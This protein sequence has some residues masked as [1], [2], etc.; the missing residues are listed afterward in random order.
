M[1]TH[2]IFESDFDCLTEVKQK[3]SSE[4]TPATPSSASSQPNAATIASLA[5]QQ[6]DASKSSPGPVELQSLSNRQYLDETVVPLLLEGLAILAKERP[7]TAPDAVEWLSAFLLKN[8]DFK[9]NNGVV[10]GT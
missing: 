7:A 2:P 9:S 1:G 5:Q 6:R 3:M 8:K 10:K 4:A